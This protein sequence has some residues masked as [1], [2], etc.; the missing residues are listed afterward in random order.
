MTQLRTIAIAIA[1]AVLT[2]AGHALAAQGCNQLQ[3][4]AGEQ[5]SVSVLLPDVATDLQPTLSAR[6]AGGDKWGACPTTGPFGPCAGHADVTVVDSKKILD[7]DDGMQL[8]GFKLKNGSSSTRDV[9]LC[10]KYSGGQ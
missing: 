5:A 10:V 7:P 4:A 8:I 2:S 3:L 9:R 6:N 1:V